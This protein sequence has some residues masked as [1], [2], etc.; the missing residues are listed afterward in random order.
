MNT[1]LNFDTR[2]VSFL[3]EQK[4]QSMIVS[5][6]SQKE[7]RTGLH[8][9]S[10]LVPESEWCTRRYT[11]DAVMPE[12]KEQAELQSWDWKRA[13]IFENGWKLHERWQ[14]TFLHS[15]CVVMNNG[16]PELDLTHYDEERQL[17]FSPD[18]IIAYGGE[19][20]VVEIKG[21]NL[22]EYERLL[23]ASKPPDLAYRQVQLYMHLLE[24]QRGV[25][26]VECKN[27]QRFKVWAVQYDRDVVQ[28]YLDRMYSVKGNVGSVKEFGLSRI[29][30]R[31]CKS[32]DVPLARRCPYAKVCFELE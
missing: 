29:K 26:L 30:L 12:R 24:L 17:Y 25:I 19:K 6:A 27:S 21:Y 8:A 2:A 1:S 28:S 10:L 4:F 20:Y 22:D 14:Q 5:R 13:N 3:L 16:K 11:L 15:G 9:S 18:A 31:V 32:R 7:A 23:V